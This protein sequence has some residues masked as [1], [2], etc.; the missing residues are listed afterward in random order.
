MHPWV[1]DEVLYLGYPT[2]RFTRRPIN[3]VG[4]TGNLQ[5]RHRTWMDPEA[6]QPSQ[7]RQVHAHHDARGE[8]GSK[9]PRLVP[10]A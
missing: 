10:P 6:G 7:R 8:G 1:G 4:F 5:H 9:R 3:H 2:R